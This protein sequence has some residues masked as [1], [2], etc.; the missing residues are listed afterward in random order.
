MYS[1]PTYDCYRIAKDVY[2]GLDESD[3]R[4]RRQKSQFAAASQSTSSV[5]KAKSTWRS[6]KAAPVDAALNE[7]RMVTATRESKF[8]PADCCIYCGW[9][10][11]Q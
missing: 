5:D 2:D 11:G 8:T 9:K 4:E 7:H 10:A 6:L 3:L 1:L